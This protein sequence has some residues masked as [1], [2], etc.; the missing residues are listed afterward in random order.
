[1]KKTAAFVL[2]V[3]LLL[4]L[5]APSA[6]AAATDAATVQQTIQAL[7]IMVGDENGNMNLAGNV[8]RAQ[9]AKMMVA[10]SAYKDS[11]SPTANSSPFKDVKYTHWAAS[12]IL[13]AVKAGWVTGYTDGTYRP[14][15]SVRLE[16][17][18]SA[19]LKML[20]YTSADFSGSFPEAQLTKYRA[21]GLHE[22]VT[23]AQGEALSRQD[24]MHLF[25]NLMGTKNTSGSYYAASLGYSV[26]SA[27][28]LDYT[29]LILNDM[30]GP[31]IVS[32]SGWSSVLPFDPG[33]A[34]IY[35][36]GA[37][38]DSA[39]VSSYDVFYYNAN[40]RTIWVY[41]HHISGVYT[42]ASPSTAAPTS[43]TVAGGT[44]SISTSSAGFALSDIGSFGIGDTVT[45]LLGMN[46]DVVGVADAEELNTT[47]YGMAVATGVKSY[48]DRSGRV[49]TANTVS[50]VC[51]DGS[52]YEYEYSGLSIDDG[53]LLQ[54]GFTGTGTSVKRLTE[55]RLAGTVNASATGLGSYTF[56]DEIRI[57]DTTA[58]NSYCKV[59]PSRL[60][61]LTLSSSK[62]RYYATD[63]SGRIS[64]LILNDVTGDAYKYGILTSVH[65]SDGSAEGSIRVS[66]SYTYLLDGSQGTFS[67]STKMFG[68]SGQGPA[69]ME[70]DGGTLVKLRKLTELSLTSLS[71]VYAQS[72]SGQYRL[73]DDC[74]IYLYS[75][76][77]SAYYLSNLS[78][79]SD[80]DSY[81]LYGY[82]DKLPGE[83]G[84]IRIFVAK[85]K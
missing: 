9:F 2:A 7:G 85:S 69:L 53:D 70:F 13:T 64:D 76:K 40:M 16:E 22:N 33:T 25:F 78:S 47:R 81:T 23:K 77:D 5:A 59:Y 31:Y 42:A 75:S 43:V 4:S 72:S 48:T 82:Y 58:N 34:A 55:K 10:A 17:A 26:N 24:C 71:S 39:S 6:S 52:I 11:V 45:L 73:S 68:I 54:I 28:E 79:V 29:S 12:Y 61:G 80:T 67:S 56:A 66:S 62:I 14:D 50:V 30:K 18:V 60:A 20:G 38:S 65:E 51:T 27:G 41:R 57:L 74:D 83:G 46:G 1:M 21:L 19:V 63:D 36:N 84:R 49:Q 15:N 8:T 44:Y 37:V 35:K 32:G 3:Y